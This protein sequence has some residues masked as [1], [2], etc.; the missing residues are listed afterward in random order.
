M[1]NNSSTGLQS[2]IAAVLA[3]LAG[4][5]SGLIFLVIEQRDQFVRFHAMQSV[6]FSAIIW[7]VAAAL[8]ILIK[9]FALVPVIG[10]VMRV[11][12]GLVE[13]VFF[14]GAFIF[15]VILIAKAYHG[16]RY[17]LPVIGDA[18]E[19]NIFKV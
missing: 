15:W 10:P 9:L 8:S 3:Y 7:V 1:H 18:A 14:V 11:L 13:S 19:A 2:N 17:K 5:I 6:M 12:I 16:E 4:W